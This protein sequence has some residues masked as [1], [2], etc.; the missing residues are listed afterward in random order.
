MKRAVLSMATNAAAS[1][2]TLIGKT[3]TNFWN[4]AAKAGEVK[5]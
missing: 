2:N 3:E 4:S 1:L 5:A